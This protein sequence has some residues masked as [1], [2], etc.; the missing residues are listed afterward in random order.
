VAGERW[1]QSG[2]F[3]QEKRGDHARRLLAH[4]TVVTSFLAL[5]FIVVPLAVAP[6]GSRPPILP[7]ILFPALFFGVGFV[8]RF[9][10]ERR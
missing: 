1:P 5:F 7:A 6:S 3:P 10:S 4:W 2:P 8:V 9:F